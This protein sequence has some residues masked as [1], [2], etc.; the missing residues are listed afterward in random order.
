MSGATQNNVIKLPAIPAPHDGFIRYVAS[1]PHTPMSELLLPYV[2]Y[3]TKLREIYAQQHN[4]VYVS[5]SHINVVSLF[6]GSEILVK[7]RARNLEGES[8][9]QAEKFLMPLDSSSR[10]KNGIQAMVPNLTMFKSNFNIFTEMSLVDLDWNNVIAAGSSVVTCLL[11]VPKK[12]ATSRR[13]Q[14]EYYHERVAPASDVD[15]FLYGL[16]EQQAIQKI[17]QI[18]QK[19]SNA[20]LHK[21]VS[22]R[23]R[24]TVTIVSEYP[25]RHVQI[26]LRAYRTMSE[27]LTGFDVDCSCAAF[28]GKNVYAT[29]RAIAAYMTQVN[30]IDLTRRS[31]SYEMR[32]WKYSRRGFEI[33]WPDLDRSRVNPAIFERSFS[34]T[35]GLARLLALEK[36]V[37]IPYGPGITAKGIERLIYR[38]DLLLNAA[39]NKPTSRIVNLHRHP[40]F[41]GKVEDII[42]DCCGSCPVPVTPED[43]QKAKEESKY[44]VSGRIAFVKT[45]PGQ[46]AIG[47]FYPVTDKDWTSTAY[48]GVTE[49][50]FQAIVDRH[51]ERVRDWVINNQAAV[52]QRDHTGRTSLQLAVSTSS[53]SIVKV[54]IDHGA[55]LNARLTDGKT[56]LHLAAIRG[57]LPIIE[58]LMERN[59]ENKALR[60]DVEGIAHA[61]VV[62]KTSKGPSRCGRLRGTSPNDDSS[63]DADY[64]ESFVAAR[65]RLLKGFG[66]DIP[67]EDA[68]DGDTFEIDVLSWD[69]PLSALHYA[70]LAGKHETIKGLIQDHEADLSM[71]VKEREDRFSQGSAPSLE[72][73]LRSPPVQSKSITRLLLALGASTKQT[74]SRKCTTLHRFVAERAPALE[75][76]FLFNRTISQ[77]NLNRLVAEGSSTKRVASPLLT[78]IANNDFSSASWLL[79]NGAE[80]SIDCK[81]WLEVHLS[82]KSTQQQKC[83]EE[84]RKL[85][86]EVVEQ[87]VVQAVLHE[88]LQIAQRLIERGAH[89]NTITSV[90]W[91]SIEKPLDKKLA[92]SSLLD[93][94]QAR[95]NELQAYKSVKIEQTPTIQLQADHMYLSDLVPA[96]YKYWKASQELKDAKLQNQETA[97]KTTMRLMQSG[98]EAAVEEKKKHIRA[99]LEAMEAFKTLL[100]EKGA[101]TFYQLYSELQPPVR[102]DSG[103]SK[104]EQSTFKTNL[105]FNVPNLTE[106]KQQG[107]ERLFEA[108]WTND[109]ETVNALTLQV[110]KDENGDIRQPLGVAV[111]DSLRLNPFAIAV[112]RGHRRL[113]RT[114]LE[115]CLAQFSP[116]SREGH[117]VWEW[118]EFDNEDDWCFPLM[119]RRHVGGMQYDSVE[120]LASD[121]ACLTH[122]LE[123]L[124]RNYPIGYFENTVVS[125]QVQSR[126]RPHSALNSD[127]EVVDQVNPHMCQEQLDTRQRP[128][129]IEKGRLVQYAVR[130]ADAALLG[131]IVDQHNLLRDPSQARWVNHPIV[132]T[133]D[134]TEAIELGRIGI[135]TEMIKRLGIPFQSFSKRS[136]LSVQTNTKQ[137][138]GLTVDGQKQKSLT[139]NRWDSHCMENERSQPPLLIA[140]FKGNL[141]TVKWFLSG[142]PE[143][144]YA[145]FLGVCPQDVDAEM[146]PPYRDSGYSQRELPTW[147]RSQNKQLLSAAVL[148]PLYANDVFDY[149]IAQHPDLVEVKS[150]K[151]GLTPCHLAFALRRSV[152]MVQA[153]LDAGA[154]Q[155]SRGTDGRNILHSLFTGLKGSG[156]I[157]Y[158]KKSVERMKA[159]W[160]LIDPRLRLRLLVERCS[161]PGTVG[162]LTPL[163]LWLSGQRRKH[164]AED[165]RGRQ[166]LSVPANE[167]LELEAILRYIEDEEATHVLGLL[168]GS[169]ATPLH[170]TTRAGHYFFSKRLLMINPRLL[171]REDATGRT[172]LEVAQDLFFADACAKPPSDLH[173]L[174]SLLSEAHSNNKQGNKKH[175][176]SILSVT[177]EK[178]IKSKTLEE[179]ETTPAQATYNMFMTLDAKLKEEG[180]A[181]RRLVTLFEAQEASDRLARQQN[182]DRMEKERLRAEKEPKSTFQETDHIDEWCEIAHSRMSDELKD[183]LA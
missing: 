38:K 92:G 151:R 175:G 161:P 174:P 94:V 56:S 125:P 159:L 70:V 97:G 41:F 142:K 40:A 88:S 80:I 15:L 93:V 21:T 14:R 129:R 116:K 123:L 101:R 179:E 145:Q 152:A 115:I 106:W 79:D 163:A 136:S 57:D 182:R 130:K 65:Q 36:T 50:L 24:N 46:Q 13:V 169:G 55:R 28:D 170:I 96:S 113:A 73:T 181:K 154:D 23:T 76:L 132:T 183:E 49:K 124:H 119:N 66:N 47:S 64:A 72:L 162:S 71:P 18:E 134:F 165:I 176:W 75:T 1:K 74:D 26:V 77:K 173:F 45:N 82:A 20:L 172:P 108:A 44:Y 4:H 139:Q 52:N 141:K 61:R 3:E 178:L 2:R 8:V 95:I 85:F 99:T 59:A 171:Y 69:V 27:I 31:P 148:A 86:R 118:H 7:I 33:H 167:L 35:K 53:L 153:L 90:G 62:Q 30:T 131:F 160:L 32:L 109:I 58:A 156:V 6:T 140:A 104:S 126:K 180:R 107:Y 84:H 111:F 102:P 67:E 137:Y 42:K 177:P 5:K 133:A 121:T 155:T 110:W 143:G 103:Q 144:L 157:P 164:V 122:P 39:W 149:V 158:T 43:C 147:L 10:K 127:C 9:R 89:V 60:Q 16:S 128:E 112:L 12:Y 168:D 117:K 29:P 81:E 135:L 120:D 166:R 54:L 87:P 11:P 146:P 83:E 37:T 17:T 78:A 138:E 22:V 68:N 105:T 25:T 48:V 63:R 98:S 51:I 150:Q 91:R 114:L 100:L 19:V 34:K